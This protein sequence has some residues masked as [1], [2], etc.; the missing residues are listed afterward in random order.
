MNMN[1]RKAQGGFTLIELVIVIV[2]LGILAAIA[3]P[4][5]IDLSDE[6]E[7]AAC[8]GV[9]GA[10]L[11]SAA[12]SIADPDV[13]G[14]GA[15]GTAEQIVTATILEGAVAQ[16]DGHDSIDYGV[17]NLDADNV[18]DSSPLNLTVFDQPE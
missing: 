9:R 18:C 4:R 14:L 16:A 15:R 12:I 3:L 8:Q 6:A 1:V 13:G 7:Q 2:L 17:P 11:S 10:L 5:Y